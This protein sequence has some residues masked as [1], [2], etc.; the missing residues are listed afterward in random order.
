[1]SVSRFL[2][3]S[4]F[5][6]GLI[7]P[8]VVLACRWLSPEAGL[9]APIF[10]VA[11]AAL[12]STSGWLIVLCGTKASPRTGIV[13]FGVASVLKLL[14]TGVVALVAKLGPWGEMGFVLIPYIIVFCLCGGLQLVMVVRRSTAAARS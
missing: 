5:L 9:Q 7:G 1:M 3:V 10:G 8:A 2:L 14:G 6:V 11:S 4:L 13:A 12:V